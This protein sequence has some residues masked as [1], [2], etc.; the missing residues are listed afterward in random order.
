MITAILK[1]NKKTKRM[2]TSSQNVK[3]SIF[4]QQISQSVA[5]I[6]MLTVTI[7]NIVEM[8]SGNQVNIFY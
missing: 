2:C 8:F 4:G 6:R 5:Y 3:Q 7:D 1:W